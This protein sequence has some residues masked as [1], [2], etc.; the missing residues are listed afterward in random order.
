MPRVR[1]VIMTETQRRKEREANLF[2]LLL[3]MPEKHLRNDLK[4]IGTL[5]LLDNSDEKIAKLADKYKVTSV[6]MTMRLVILYN[7]G[8]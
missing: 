8:I 5:D 2:A 1:T 4:D 7:E 6:M 3:L